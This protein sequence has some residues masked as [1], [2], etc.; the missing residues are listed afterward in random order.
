LT[1][2]I[3]NQEKTSSILVTAQNDL[4]APSHGF[5]TH[6]SYQVN[7]ERAA[8]F[9]QVPVPVG[10]GLGNYVWNDTLKEYVPGK[11][12]E[13]TIQEQ[14]VYGSA[15]ESRVRKTLLN[16]TWTLNHSHKH[17][18]PGILADLDWSG[19]LNTDEQLSIDQPLP[20][21]SWVPGFGSLFD[22]NT[23]NDSLVR[24]ADLSYRQNLEW[25]PDGLPGVHGKLYVQ[26]SYKKIRD[27]SESGAEYGAGADRTIKAWFLGWEG[28]ITSVTRKSVDPAADNNYQVLDRHAL[29]TE[30]CKFYRDFSAYLKE[31]GGFASKTSDAEDDQGF[32][33]RI[34]PGVLWQPSQKG[35]A[36]LSYTYSSVNIPGTLDYRMAQGFSAGIS[37]TIELN[38]HLNFGTHFS[39]D[40]TYRGLFGA[41]AVSKSGLH[42]VSMQMKAYL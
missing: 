16:I 24:F 1:Q 33:Y 6:Q 14:Q 4:S 21:S 7:I 22:K 37:H 40:I 9:V 11:N 29:L 39:A 30:K 15:S 28:S 5:S 20:T 3:Y 8:S 17:K 23:L 25:N 35:L 18:L 34:V 26:P 42:T 12:G 19:A 2:D 31:A 10:K 13:Y 32:Y 36:E 38:S 27:Y 41:G